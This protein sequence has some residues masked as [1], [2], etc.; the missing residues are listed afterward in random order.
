MNRNSR[1]HAVL[2]AASYIVKN[3]GVEKLTLEAV[4]KEAGISKGG[5]LH[6]FPSKEALLIG[7][8]EELTDHFVADVTARAANAAASA[9]K[10]SRAYMEATF[11]DINKGGISTAFTASLYANPDLLVKLERV[12]SD[13]QK[14]MENDGIDPVQA[15]IVR[16]AADGLWFSE[17]FGLGKI[18]ED[19]RE[20]VIHSLR[21]MID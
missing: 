21:N 19:L 2:T 20:K 1:R 9:G 14:N 5:L 7:M 18:D 4:A 8:V 11:D 6:H 16:L 15:T 13:W 17:L 3:H 10:W 12:Y